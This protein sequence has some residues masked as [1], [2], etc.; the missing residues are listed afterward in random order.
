[1]AAILL[2]SHAAREFA[3]SKSMKGS[4]LATKSGITLEHILSFSSDII[5]TVP[6]EL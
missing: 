1:M 5:I 2:Y 4:H 6:K 3:H